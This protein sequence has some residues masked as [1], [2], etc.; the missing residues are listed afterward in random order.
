[1]HLILLVLFGM[2]SGYYIYLVC[3]GCHRSKWVLVKAFGANR[4]ELLN[5]RWNFEC[6]V[7]GPM[8]EKPLQAHEEPSG[9]GLDE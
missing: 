1:M 8:C 5:T 6:P 7:H 3:P 4:D 9:F 2:N